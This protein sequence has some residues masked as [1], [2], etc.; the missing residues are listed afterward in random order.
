MYLGIVSWWNHFS[1]PRI[2]LTFW[3]IPL[4]KS[5]GM[6]YLLLVPLYIIFYFG[7]HVESPSHQILSL[8][9][10]HG[11]L[12]HQE[13]SSFLT[14]SILIKPRLDDL[15]RCGYLVFDGKYFRLTARGVRTARFLN[16]YQKILGRGMGG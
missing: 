7:T 6:I 5:A 12:S 9:K 4:Y 16:I 15:I 14:D 1:N 8:I 13:L 3:N 11:E 10:C 2:P